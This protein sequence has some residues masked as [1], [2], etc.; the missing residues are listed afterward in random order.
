[1]AN[2]IVHLIALGKAL[3]QRD[4]R[5]RLRRIEMLRDACHQAGMCRCDFQFK[6][7]ARRI[8][9]AYVLAFGQAQHACVLGVFRR[10]AHG[11]FLR[12]LFGNNLAIEKEMM[13]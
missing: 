6:I 10:K 8:D 5:R 1:M 12:R 9:D 7:I 13:E 11:E 4:A 2:D 3:E